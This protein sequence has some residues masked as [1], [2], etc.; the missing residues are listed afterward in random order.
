M[1]SIGG[2]AR[3][4]RKT[5]PG[6]DPNL[7]YLT[8]I[9]EEVI[10]LERL[11]ENLLILAK[12]TRLDAKIKLKTSLDFDMPTIAFDRNQLRQVLLNLFQNALHAMPNGGDL[13]VTTRQKEAFVQIVVQDTGVGIPDEHLDRLFVPFFTTKPSGAGLGLSI[14]HKILENHN[15][16]IEVTSQEGVGTTFVVNL[17]LG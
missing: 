12:P 15:G 2:F 13:N 7:E 11:I 4:I 17:P 14:T 9:S 16:F 5:L 8:I 10:R 1:V 6:S 3:L